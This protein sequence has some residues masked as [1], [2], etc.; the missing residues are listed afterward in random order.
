[1]FRLVEKQPVFD[2]DPRSQISGWELTKAGIKEIRKRIGKETAIFEQWIIRKFRDRGNNPSAKFFDC[3]IH[4]LTPRLVSL[5]D[6]ILINAN[7]FVSRSISEFTK[8]FSHDHPP[9]HLLFHTHDAAWFERKG[10]Y[11]S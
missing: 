3:G 6:C 5:S 11:R 2:S 4:L 1:M 7:V 8:T 9:R 10:P